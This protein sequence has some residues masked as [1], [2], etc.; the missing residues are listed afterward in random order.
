MEY[1]ED[2]S[3]GR[4]QGKKNVKN[5][6][7]S[8]IAIASIPVVM[9][10]GNSML[11]PILPTMEKELNIS[12]FQSSL[13]ITVYSVVAIFF[14]PIAGYLS[15]KWGRKKVII[16]SLI[17]TG[18]GGMIS[19]Y[20]S[21]KL[22]DPYGWILCGRTLQGIGA[23][24]AFP[25]VLPLVGDMFR[26][27]KDVSSTLGIIETANTFGKVLSPIL[28]A[29]LATIIWYIPFFSIP[30]L[31]LLAIVLMIFFIKSKQN[32][33]A[34]PLTEFLQ[35][36]KRT[37]K[38]NNRWLYSVFF[39]GGNHMFILF[40]VLFYFSNIMEKNYRIGDLNKGFIL[41]ISLGA[42]CLASF[43]SGKKIGEDQQLM[44]KI[45]FFGI[46]LL[47]VNLIFLIFT[48]NFILSIVFFSFACI[49]IGVGLPCLD[50][51]ITQGIE[52]EKRGT[53]TSLYSSIRFIGVALGPPIIA[54]L[55][56]KMDQNLYYI[57]AGLTV[58][59]ALICYFGIRP[60]KNQEKYS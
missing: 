57:L 16:P 23:A 42:L 38:M 22:A 52:K 15:D 53:I 36:L 43:I 34:P 37:L 49:G 10:L 2:I 1:V 60:E 25:I 56:K 30:V 48:K 3:Y 54:L 45:T 29:L 44:K 24:G 28:G 7:W 55:M 13:I 11:I 9:T 31:C 14:I 27:E 41:A 39:I 58:M 6:R 12:S 26:S 50:S 33:E 35:Q 17:I 20:A 47:V 51:L 59:T 21:W 18:I 4:D 40:G 8:I 5:R 19:A 32:E 46:L